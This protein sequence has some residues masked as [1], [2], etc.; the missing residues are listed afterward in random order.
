[1]TE[2]GCPSSTDPSGGLAPALAAASRLLLLKIVD[3]ATRLQ[4][5][6]PSVAVAA[7]VAA[8]H[9]ST[10]LL[11]P[12]LLLQVEEAVLLAMSQTRRPLLISSQFAKSGG[13]GHTVRVGNAYDGILTGTLLVLIPALVWRRRPHLGTPH[14]ALSW[15]GG[16]SHLG[17]SVGCYN[18]SVHVSQLSNCVPSFHVAASGHQQLLFDG[19]CKHP[20]LTLGRRLRLVFRLRLRL[21]LNPKL[22]SKPPTLQVDIA[23]HQWDTP[24]PSATCSVFLHLPVCCPS[25]S[26][27]C[28]FL[29]QLRQLWM[30][31]RERSYGFARAGCSSGG[32][33]P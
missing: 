17:V 21:M 7:A 24:R 2:P 18:G 9:Q 33:E 30:Q 1:M 19:L 3:L 22:Y 25:P 5:Q 20:S 26:V 15:H 12:L 27:V 23:L 4:G 11:C 10:L 28:C 6:Q 32:R 31:Q 14:S 16:S 13:P 29:F 8:S